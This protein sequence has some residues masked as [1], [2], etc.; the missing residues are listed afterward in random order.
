MSTHITKAT[1][2]KFQRVTF[3][4]IIPSGNLIALVG[5]NASGKTSTIDGLEAALCGHD[6]RTIRRPIQDGSGKAGIEIQ[7]SDGS[8]LIR[9]YTPSGST[10]KG[11]DGAGAKFGQTEINNRLSSLGID[12]RKFIRLDDKKQLE[13]LL[14]IVALPFKPA[15]LEAQK[16]ALETERTNVGRDEKAIGDPVVD[17]ALPVEVPSAGDLIEAIRAGEASNQLIDTADHSVQ[18]WTEELAARKEALA[19]AERN[20]AH[21]IDIQSSAPERID[22]EALESELGDVETKAAAI[23]ANN[24]A[25]AMVERKTELKTRY[26]ALTSEIKAIADRKADGLAKAVMPIDGLTFDDEG[27]LYQGVPFS[28]ASGREQL[29]VSCAMIMAT[30]PEIR[31]IVVRDGNVLDIEGMQILQDMAEATDFQIFIE[32]VADVQGDHEHYFVDGELAE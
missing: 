19:I 8:K 17:A 32:I 20:L 23:R 9:G 28:R 5:K 29:I 14:S 21:A 18:H 13:A 25:L 3:A 26:A 22:V 10:L 1:L 16:K 27:V 15:E 12:G 7:L 31:V 4:E 24:N 6:S 11:T 2:T 30:D